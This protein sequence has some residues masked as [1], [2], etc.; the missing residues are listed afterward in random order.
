[1]NFNLEKGLF[2]NDDNIEKLKINILIFKNKYDTKIHRL[3]SHRIYFRFHNLMSELTEM[4]MDAQKLGFEKLSTICRKLVNY[5]KKN[6]NRNDYF[7]WNYIDREIKIIKEL[8][9]M[10]LVY[11]SI[12]N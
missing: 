12:N 3:Y 9:Q 2:N 11:L 7:I 6:I 1:M 5:I 8:Y 10:S 4:Y